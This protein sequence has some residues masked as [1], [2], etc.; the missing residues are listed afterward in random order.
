MA[1]LRTLVRDLD[2][3]MVSISVEKRLKYLNTIE[4]W[5][6][7]LTHALVEVQ[8]LYGKLLHASLVVPAGRTYLTNL[9]AMLSGFNSSPF[10][11]HT[12]PRSTPED[13]R[14]WARRL[15][16]PTLSRSIPGPVPVMDCNAYS[17]ASSGFSIGITIGD[18]WRTWH[19]LPTWKSDGHDIGWA[20]AVGFEV[21]TL[22]IISS[23]NDSTHFKVYGNNE[24]VV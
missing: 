3:C 13:L 2:A 24:G 12:P 1:S 19:L 18:R 7:K 14:W 8:K 6:R 17:D 11:P 20:E 22:F 9:E 4:E 23:S 21:L 5:E 10:M 16:S 15:Q